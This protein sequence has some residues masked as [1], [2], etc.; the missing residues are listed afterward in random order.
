MKP[1]FARMQH[2]P[3]PAPSQLPCPPSYAS[4]KSCV[5]AWTSWHAPQI[6]HILLPA[7]QKGLLPE[8]RRRVE[9]GEPLAALAAEH[10]KCPSRG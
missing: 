5:L 3:R 8:L 9:A 6:S 1:S 10:S 2:P 7:D 4:C